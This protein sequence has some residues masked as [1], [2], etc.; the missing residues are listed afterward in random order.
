MN[1]TGLH[2]LI[3]LRKSRADLESEARG[4]GDTLARHRTLLLDYASHTGLAVGAVYEEVVSGDTIAARPQMQRLLSEVAA[5]LWQAVLVVEVPRLARGDTADQGIVAKTFKYSGTLILTPS[6]VYDPQNESDE[7]YFEFGLF[8]SRREYQMINRRLKAGRYASMREGKYIG[9]VPPYGYEI[10]R[11]KGEK[12]NSLRPVPKEAAVV[13]RVFR[14]FLAGRTQ[15]AIAAGLNRCGIPSARGKRWTVSSIQSLLR[16]AHYAGY[17]VSGFR[18]SKK[19]LRNGQLVTTRPRNSDLQLYPGRHDA[20][21][22]K[23]DYHRAIEILHTHQAPPVPKKSGASNPLSGL[24]ICSCCGKKMQRR[25]LPNGQGAQLLCPT[26]GCIT[27]SHNADEI[28]SLILQELQEWLSGFTIKISNPQYILPELESKRSALSAVDQQI[29]V[30]ESSQQKACELVET[31]IYTAELFQSRQAAFAQKRAALLSIKAELSDSIETTEHLLDQHTQSA[32]SIQHIL[33]IYRK[34]DPLA[35]NRLLKAI[36][37]RVEYHKTIGLRWS[38][39][40]DL[41]L[42]LY[43]KFRTAEPSL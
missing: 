13:Q 22:S 15:S 33:D 16:N 24:V 36:L 14:E 37:V 34:A 42:T 38:S 4:E 28:E 8:M 29:S 1:L 2:T 26:K 41:T 9:S 6:K 32:P 43:P 7:E 21:I 20:L 3:Y 30:L 40:T 23:E 12:G 5:G 18:P 11:L 17:T 25:P 39:E 27:V 35:R 19:I 31:G 10:Y